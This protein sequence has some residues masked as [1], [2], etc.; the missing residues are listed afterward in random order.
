[1]PRMDGTGPFGKGSRDGRQLGNCSHDDDT[2]TQFHLGKG[3]GF[4]KKANS[5]NGTGL[6]RRHRSGDNE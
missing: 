3:L 2:S 4:R 6:G 5:P 1:M